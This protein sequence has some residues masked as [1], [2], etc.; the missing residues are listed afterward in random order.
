VAG[1]Y[2]LTRDENQFFK[3][4]MGKDSADIRVCKRLL[5]IEFELVFLLKF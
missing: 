4:L 1:A 2:M 5:D 3:L